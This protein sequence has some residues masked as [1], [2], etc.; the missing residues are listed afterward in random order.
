MTASVQKVIT[1]L[2]AAVGA[3]IMVGIMLAICATMFLI[4]G[5]AALAGL[6]Q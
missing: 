4:F 6:F 3:V 2:V 1:Y 5:L